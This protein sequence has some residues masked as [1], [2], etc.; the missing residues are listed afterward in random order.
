[1]A[2]DLTDAKIIQLEGVELRIG[3]LSDRSISVIAFP[4]TGMCAA[5]DIPFAGETASI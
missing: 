2:A 3:K 5:V 4:V 1:L